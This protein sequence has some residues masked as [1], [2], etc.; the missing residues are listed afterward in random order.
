MA[1]GVVST[2]GPRCRCR[3]A[4]CTAKSLSTTCDIGTPSD[5]GQFR[6]GRFFHL[7]RMLRRRESALADLAGVGSYGV[8][9][10]FTEDRVALGVLQRPPVVVNAEHVVQ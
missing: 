4:S 10:R 5:R 3:S 9:D 8:A 6:H 1:S 2:T 7:E